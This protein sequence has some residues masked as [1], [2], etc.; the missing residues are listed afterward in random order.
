MHTS[1]RSLSLGLA[2]RRRC[3]NKVKKESPFVGFILF[4]SAE[5]RSSGSVDLGKCFRLAGF[6][7]FEEAQ[8]L[9]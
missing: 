7:L 8:R 2:L 5:R 1:S 4:F 6:V 9:W 3:D